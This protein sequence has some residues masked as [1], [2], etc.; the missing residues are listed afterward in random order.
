MGS[1]KEQG[2]LWSPGARDWAD[3]NEPM[4]TPFYEAVLDAT[5]V[6][7]GTTVLDVG[8]GGGFALLLASRRGAIVTG[9]DAAPEMVEVARERVPHASLTVGDIAEPLPYAPGTFDVVTAFNAVQFSPDPVA[10]IA[11][12]KTA[13]RPG[14][15]I[16]LLVW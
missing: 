3:Y 2:Q 11:H 8:C 16:A 6:T 1:G 15:R 10:T 14:G 7:H 12:M 5:G 4:C 9:L 13:A